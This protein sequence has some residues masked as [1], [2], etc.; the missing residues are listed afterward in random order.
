MKWKQKLEE[1]GLT[2]E[3]ISQG[4]RTKIKDF[5]EIIDGIEECKKSLENPSINDDVDE[6]R[7]DLE[8]LE[9]SLDDADLKLVRAIEVYDRNKE[10]YA[11]ISKNLSNGRPRKDGTPNAPKQQIPTQTQGQQAPKPQVAQQ[12]GQTNELPITPTEEV[13]NNEVKKGSGLGWKIFV[14]VLAVATLGVAIKMFK[15]REE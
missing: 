3:T 8:G 14:G 15:N 2:E 5:Y 1:C 13:A 6:L 4:L 10:K 12:G 9:E 11:Q 7:S